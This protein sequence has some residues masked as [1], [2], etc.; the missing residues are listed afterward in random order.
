M[1]TLCITCR[2][3][4][5]CAI[6]Q[7]VRGNLI[8]ER[9]STEDNYREC[10]SWS[11]VGDREAG[12]RSRAYKHC[13]IG[14]YRAINSLYQT[15]L[16]D[17]DVDETTDLGALLV[18]GME[19]AVREEQL[20]YQT[21]EHGEFLLDHNG[22]RIPRGTFVLRRYA[23][24][25]EG[26][27]QESRE[28]VMFWKQKNLIDA[29]IRAERDAKLISGK[30]LKNQQ[31]EDEESQKEEE[32]MAAPKPVKKVIKKISMKSRPAGKPAEEESNVPSKAKGPVV[33]KVTGKKKPLPKKAAPVQESPAQESVGIGA[34]ALQEMAEGIVA[35][36]GEA[37]AAHKAEVL[38]AVEE[39]VTEATQRLVGCITVLHDI[40][41]Q[42]AGKTHEDI[43]TLT[44]EGELEDPFDAS[45]W[46][47]W[48]N[49]KTIESY[50]EDAEDPQ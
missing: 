41:L 49:G 45:G 37:L 18:E 6:L 46:A 28:K 26:P 50:M 35:Q 32:E 33:K 3:L 21:D 11:P 1:N 16:E 40:N 30:R 34:E 24:D 10:T 2:H 5:G 4:N 38:A 44:A 9:L 13:G 15:I 42:V 17:K 39:K 14:M 25:P 31:K 48:E 12:V 36:V 8:T 20:M 27:I 29:I 43:L 47:L 19:V 22:R 23:I 7:D